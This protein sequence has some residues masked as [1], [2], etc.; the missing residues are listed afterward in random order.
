[1]DR[2]FILHSV[3][4]NRV[5]GKLNLYCIMRSIY[6]SMI[7][8][9]PNPLRFLQSHVLLGA[10]QRQHTTLNGNLFYIM[11]WP[12]SR[13][14]IIRVTFHHFVVLMENKQIVIVSD[15]QCH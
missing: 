1:M 2:A 7:T 11:H 8:E 4:N 9:L 5:K 15:D 13:G 14:E 3:S 6:T 12:Q 10:K